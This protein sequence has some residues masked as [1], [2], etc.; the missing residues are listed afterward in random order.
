MYELAPLARD[1]LVCSYLQM[2]SGDTF[3]RMLLV[4]S[5]LCVC[6]QRVYELSKFVHEVW[7]F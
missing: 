1:H 6:H 2:V 5:N 3:M 7:S 4:N